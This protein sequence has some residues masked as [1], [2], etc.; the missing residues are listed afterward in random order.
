MY[1]SAFPMLAYFGPDKEISQVLND[2]YD[3]DSKDRYASEHNITLDVTL[4][5]IDDQDAQERLSKMLKSGSVDEVMIFLNIVK[6]IDR[7]FVLSE[8]AELLNDQRETHVQRGG[9]GEAGIPARSL[10]HLCDDTPVPQHPKPTYLRVCDRAL[11]VLASKAKV[12][13]GVELIT[14]A[15]RLFTNDEL[16]AAYK[17]L[18]AHFQDMEAKEATQNSH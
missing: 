8:A 9:I 10:I 2:Q 16:A 18:K 1:D 4:A 15:L 11:Y 17:I 6:R 7:P 13:V 12:D 5:Q 14:Y 3:H